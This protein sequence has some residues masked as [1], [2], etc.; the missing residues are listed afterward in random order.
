M[1]DGHRLFSGVAGSGKTIILLA[2]AKAIANRLTA[3][4]VLI[5][6]FNITLASHLR[7][8]LHTD[9]QNPQYRERI[10]VR[11]FHDWA[12]SLLGR[13]PSFAEFDDGEEYNEFI[14]DQALANLNQQATET[15]WDS[16]LVDEAHTFS[17]K[18]FRCCVAALK[19]PIAGDLMIV[20]D[21]S[22]SLYARRKFTWKSVGIQAAGRSRR[23][24]QN[25]RNTQEVLTAAWSVVQPVGTDQ[26]VVEENVTFPVVEPSAALR[27]GAKPILH[28]MPSKAQAIDAL[29]GQ[30][31]TLA[32]AG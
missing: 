11:H 9:E 8:I 23:L 21:G 19:D 1:R 28:L 26:P 32:E 17:P 25:Y 22:Q 16:V 27:Q 15:K 18:W 10:E 29:V 5:L 14:G 7:S 20:S 24:A 31:R 6:C 3:H 4:R 13:L 30:V 12:K 2:R